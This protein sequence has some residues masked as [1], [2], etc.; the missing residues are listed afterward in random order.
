MKT[1]KRTLYDYR[2][3]TGIDA[4][5]DTALFDY[6]LIWKQRGDDYHF[7]FGVDLDE[8]GE[9]K[10][11]DWADVPVNT[12][13]ELVFSQDDYQDTEPFIAIDPAIDVRFERHVRTYLRKLAKMTKANEGVEKM[14]RHQ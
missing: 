6:G 12:G 9:Y 8:N 3:Y 11:F 10:S 2:G 14:L 5:L 13:I 4:S 7:I 1:R